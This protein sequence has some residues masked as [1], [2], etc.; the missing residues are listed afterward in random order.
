MKTEIEDIQFS[1][2][3]NS[4]AIN[5]LAAKHKHVIITVNFMNSE[6]E[7]LLKLKNE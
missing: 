2:N 6:V 4:A 7:V 5:S 3:F 1:L